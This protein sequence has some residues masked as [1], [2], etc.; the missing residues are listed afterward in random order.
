MAFARFMATPLG[1]GIRIIAGV[2]ALIAGAGLAYAGQT[3]AGLAL[4]AVGTA[5]AMV[6]IA[7]VCPLALLFGGPF[8]GRRA[9]RAA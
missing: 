7:N 4:T 6:G 2:I 1:R 3:T 9:Q 5:L 8:D